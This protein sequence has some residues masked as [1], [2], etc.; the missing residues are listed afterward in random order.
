MSQRAPRH[1]PFSRPVR[2]H[3]PPERSR[4]EGRQY[5]TNSATWR[6]IREQVLIRDLYT[7]QALG[8]GKLVGGKGE[9][10]VDHVDNDPSNNDMANLQTLCVPCHSSK[11]ATE[12]GG[13]GNQRADAAAQSYPQKP[14]Q[15]SRT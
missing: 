9:A 8:C 5:A 6:R 2:R 1:D 15:K 3:A 14:E 11:T 10:H 12:D 7:C 4:Q 13:F